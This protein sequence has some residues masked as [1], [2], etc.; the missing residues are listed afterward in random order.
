MIDE[1]E[2]DVGSKLAK[3]TLLPLFLVFIVY[4]FLWG[5]Q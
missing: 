2:L 5:I 3:D 1:K 4:M